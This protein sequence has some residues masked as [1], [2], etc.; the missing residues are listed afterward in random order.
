MLLEAKNIFVSF[1]KENQTSFFGKERQEVVK[2][3]SI[4]LKKGE[5]LGIIGESGSGKS[6]FG[7]TLIGLLT[8]DKGD[9]TVNGISLYGKS[10][11]DEKRKVKQAVSV[12]FQDYTSS[13]NPR[14]R[15]KD[16]IGE[17]LRV[18]EKRE[19]IK[20]DKKKRTEELLEL[21]GLNKN[22]IDRYPH[23]LSGGQLQRVCIA[24]AVATNPEIILLDEA[25]SSLD[26][27]TQTQVMDLLK[28]LQKEFG[29]SYIFITHDLPSV[30]YMCDRVI[31]FYDG[32]IV[33]QVDDIYMLSEVKSSYAAK[34]LHSILEIDIQNEEQRSYAKQQSYS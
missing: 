30:T 12:V 19:N 4:S 8:P 21:V 11:R 6:T 28:N 3:V 24:R 22:F 9:V 15:I 20:I 5:C 10:S 16:I 18:I 32:K 7:K 17:S 13:A 27:S 14:F 26:A 25:I 33:E 31:F 1:K 2:D 23:E 29:F 34:L